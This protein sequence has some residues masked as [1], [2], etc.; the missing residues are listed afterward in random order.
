MHTLHLLSYRYRTHISHIAPISNDYSH[1]RI[2]ACTHSFIHSN[3]SSAIYTTISNLTT[4]RLYYRI[5]HLSPG[6]TSL[7]SHPYPSILQSACPMQCNVMLCYHS[8]YSIPSY[9]YITLPHSL[10]II[11]LGPM[12]AAVHLSVSSHAYDY[13]W[14]VINYPLHSTSPTAIQS[15]TWCH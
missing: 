4:N 7:P 6:V 2:H 3:I 5:A 12:S 9:G 1:P 11:S 10:I 13:Y 8:P 14:C 15:N